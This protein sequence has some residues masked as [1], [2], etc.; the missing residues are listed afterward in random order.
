LTKSSKEN[1]TKS[2]SKSNNC[3]FFSSQNTTIFLNSEDNHSPG[4]LP[5]SLSSTALS[6]T[7]PPFFHQSSRK[8][9]NELDDS[10]CLSI[11][12]HN[13][14]KKDLEDT[15]DNSSHIHKKQKLNY[16]LSAATT[17]SIDSAARFN[18]FQFTADKQRGKPNLSLR[19]SSHI[20]TNERTNFQTSTLA[21]KENNAI[22]R[23]SDMWKNLEEFD[24][25]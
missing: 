13:T 12:S 14:K 6:P 10:T 16:S 5:P 25:F 3:H 21:P 17:S 8:R 11:G 4:V 22:S 19:L 20:D 24:P 18:M 1:V 7:P 15:K 23:M 9:E 2:I